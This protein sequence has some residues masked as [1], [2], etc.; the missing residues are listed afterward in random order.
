MPLPRCPYCL[1]LFTRSRYHPDQLVCSGSDCQRQRRTDYHRQKL[2]D[3]PS[4][5]AQC[6]DSQQQWRAQ[7]PEYM[8]NY[9]RARGRQPAKVPSE[10]SS[11]GLARL[12]ECV[13][14]NVAADLT[15][16]RARVW[17]ISSDE[18][19]KNIL[20]TVELI[21]VEGLPSDA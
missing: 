4:Y 12:L 9:R 5:R 20:A 17:L 6:R 11:R 1:E 15:S 10:A 18:R 13:K 21:L 2:N 8:R 3:D 19:V 14:N 7:H 16:C